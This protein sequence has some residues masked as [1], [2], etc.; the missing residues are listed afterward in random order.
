MIDL[1]L[2]DCLEVMATLPENSVDTVITDP[3]YGLT[4]MGKDW[5]R[6]VPGVAFWREALRVAKPGAMLLAM[7][8]T[9]TFHRLVCAIEDAGW[10]I[11]DSIAYLYGSGFPKSF[12]IHKGLVKKYG[13]SEKV[14]EHNLRFVREADLSQTVDY[15]DEQGKVLQSGVSEQGSPAEKREQFST[16]EVRSGQSGVEGRGD[17]LQETRELQANQVREMPNGISGNGSKRRLRDGTSVIDGNENRQTAGKNGSGTS[18]QSQSARQSVG[19]SD[20]IPEQPDAQTIRSWHGWGTALK[21]AME[22]ICVAMKPIDG[23]FVHNALTWGVAGLWIDGGRVE[24]NDNLNGGTFGGVFGN[25]KPTIDKPVGTG[26]FPA[27]IIHDGSDEVTGL[28]PNSVT[29]RIEKPCPSP[30]IDG[31]KWGT[32]QSNRGARGYDGNGSAA[33]FFYCAKASRSE[34]NA[35]LEGMEAIAAQSTG[36]SGDGMPLRQDGTER[37]MPMKQNHHPTVKPLA[38]MRYLARLTKTPTGGVVLDPF[39]GSGTTGCA[40]VLEGRDFIGI[41]LNADYMEIAAKRIQYAQGAIPV[42]LPLFE[43]I[44][45]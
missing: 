5:D 19:K 26:R 44:S 10:E 36:W 1:R 41:E 40:A 20:A 21:P 15:E 13:D 2:G 30:E 22:L 42:E 28:F 29:Q 6:G 33:R 14:S 7:G 37:K 38:L 16:A 18:Y 17:L 8:G 27:N 31:Y 23:G 3:P 24:T 9:R 4:F 43:D 45:A 25:G 32:M 39:M 35:G 34:R 12:D 11:R